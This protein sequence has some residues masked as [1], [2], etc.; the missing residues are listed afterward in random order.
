MIKTLSRPDQK[1]IIQQFVNHLANHYNSSLQIDSWPDEERGTS[2]EIDAIA[3]HFAIEHTSIDTIPNQRRDA[4]WFL[5]AVGSLEEEFFGKLPFR[6]MVILPYEGIQTGQDWSLIRAALRSWIQDEAFDLLE[7]SHIIR[8]VPGVPFKFQVQ[9]RAS[10]QPRLLFARTAPE[11]ESLYKR[12]RKQL[13]RKAEKLLPYKKQGRT[14]ILLIESDDIA[15]MDE[16]RMWDGIKLAY[17]D[18][19][20]AGVDQIWFADTSIPEHLLFVDLSTASGR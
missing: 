17:S 13:G 15:L 3:G 19:L 7:G 1:E 4:A 9:K 11:D 5:Q 6:L 18:G 16:A 20:P 14:T 12:L 8:D 2:K 10:R